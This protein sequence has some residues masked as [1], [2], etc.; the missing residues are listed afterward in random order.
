MAVMSVYA[1]I[2]AGGSGT[3]LWPRSRRRQPKHLLALE[4]GTAPLLRQTFERIHTLVDDVYVVTEEHQ[5]ESILEVLPE[6]ARD[7]VIVEPV[8][9]GTTSALG[10]AAMSLRRRDPDAVMLSLPADHIIGDSRRFK[11]TIRR[12]VRLA[13]ASSQMVTV[14][15]T[16]YYPATGFGYIRTDSEVRFGRTTGLKVAE[17]VE[18]PEFDRAVSFLDNGG[19]YWNLAIFCWRVDVLLGELLMHS[20]VHHQLLTEVVTRSEIADRETAAAIYRGLPSEAIDYTVMQKTANL[21]LIPARFHWI[22]VG[23]WSELHSILPKDVAGNAIAGDH[24]FIDS[25]SSLFDVP[26]KFVAAIGVKDLIVVESGDAL[27]ICQR[28]RS[29]EVKALVENLRTGAYAGFA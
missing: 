10:L 27:L 6:I 24:L 14:G 29:Q 13:E 25:Q 7:H 11:Q 20:P 19:Y 2:L 22:D 17:F 9:R 18:K 21:L 15:L 5:V 26:G 8:A 12:V 1:T 4:H 28:S 23:S 16:P 3:R